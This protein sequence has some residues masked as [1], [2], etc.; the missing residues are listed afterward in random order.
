MR[1]VI[2][3][4]TGFLGQ[5]LRDHLQRLG[6]TTVV[7]TRKPQTSTQV[8]WSPD[9]TSGPWAAALDGADAV[10]N[11]SGEG[12]ADARWNAARKAALRASRVLPTRSLVAAIG[13]LARPP[14]LLNASGVGYYGDRGA[15]L[16]TEDTSAG[17]DFLA[18][19]CVEWERE[20]EQAAAHTRVVV[21]R[22]GL[23]MHPSGGALKKMLL[24]FRLGAG[25][26]LGPGTQYLPWIHLVDWVEMITWLIQQP[27]ARGPFNVTAPSPA[28]NA[29]F[30]RALGRAVNRPAV[31]PVPAFALRL[32]L[33]ELAD[34]L[35]TGQRAIPARAT[36]S[37]FSFRFSEIGSALNNLL[38]R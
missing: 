23:V 20:A 19:L 22:N 29:D 34:T 36:T 13:G 2:A 4:G 24:P 15:E 37:G 6:H 32:A 35:L 21:L 3:G 8:A 28:T 12:I 33:G 30:T 26:P 31:I 18:G 14:A 17:D 27:E 9:G 7:L 10:V 38:R 1:I 25:G 5:A 11:L 16:V